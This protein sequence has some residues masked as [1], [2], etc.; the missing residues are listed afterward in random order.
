M[1]PKII[2]FCVPFLSDNLLTINSP[3]KTGIIVLFASRF[4]LSKIEEVTIV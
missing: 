3:P 4:A 2:Y 1:F